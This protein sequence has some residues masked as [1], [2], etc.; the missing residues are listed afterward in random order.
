[1]EWYYVRHYKKTGDGIIV[2]SGVSD[3]EVAAF[4][5]AGKVIPD[6]FYRYLSGEFD[7]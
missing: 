7:E 3:P 2:E 5:L 1:M 6:F 4:S